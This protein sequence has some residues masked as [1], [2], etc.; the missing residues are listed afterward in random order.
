M[1]MLRSRW[2]AG[3]VVVTVAGQLLG[4]VLTRAGSGGIPTR[5]AATPGG[6]PIT[7]L[8]VRGNTLVN[9]DGVPVRL[10]GF[11]RYGTEY[12]CVE[13]WGVLDESGGA[14]TR[15]PES[16]VTAMADWMGANAV[17]VPLNEHCRLG[18]GVDPVYSGVNY[19]DAIRDYVRLLRDHGFVV[20]L[21]PHRSAPGPFSAAVAAPSRLLVSC[22]SRGT[23]GKRS[24][25]LHRDSSASTTGPPTRFPADC[26]IGLV[27]NAERDV[28]VGHGGGPG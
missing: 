22:S 14:L 17:R 10:F 8:S 2:V 11:N 9:Q 5:V 7:A 26:R 20:V 6:V 27:P 28:S 3:A 13:G 16:T 12:A 18:L 25:P 19:R 21:D 4:L 24:S 15:I 23:D 1:F